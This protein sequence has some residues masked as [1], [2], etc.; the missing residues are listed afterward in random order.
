[1][2][3][4]LIKIRFN[5]KLDSYDENAR[6]QNK[7]AKKLIEYLPKNDY[8]SVLELGCGTGM[9]TRYVSERINY[10]NY[11]ALDIVPNCEKYIKQLNPEIEFVAG[12]I[13]E[14]VKNSQQQYDLI[15][16]NAALQWIENLPEFIKLLTER[17]NQSGILLFST[18]GTENFREIYYVIGKTLPYYSVKEFQTA[19]TKFE[20]RI[21][22]ELHVMAFKTP[23]EV[24]K[25]IQNTGVNAISSESWTKKDLAE[26]E[27]GYNN[28]CSNKPTL[29]YNPVYVMIQK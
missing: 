3:K 29:T 9:L 23:I 28:F 1:M 18:F 21:E 19:L 11:L 13:E 27:N 10:E 15:V 4:E 8:G 24:L 22:E 16:S 26:F 6:I 2:N 25:H 12:D 14:F 17:L 7:M 20:P 5:K